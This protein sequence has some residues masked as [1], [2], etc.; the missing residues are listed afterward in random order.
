MADFIHSLA[1]Q[2]CQAPQLTCYREYVLNERRVQNQ[3]SIKEC[4]ENPDKSFIEGIL[5]PL[6]FLRKAGKLDQNQYVILIDALCEAEFHRPDYGESLISFLIKHKLIIP[7]FL[8]FIATIRTQF[9]QL[10]NPLNW[11]TISLNDTHNDDDC[12]EK[13]LQIYISYRMAQS[14]NLLTNITSANH[15]HC[16]QDS[17]SKFSKYL[18][19]NSEGSFLFAKL[20]LDLLQCGQLV[21]KSSNFR[22][23]PV[24]LSQIFLL[25]FNLRFPSLQ[26]YDKVSTILSICLAAL[27]PLTLIEIYYSL[28]SLLMNDDVVTWPEFV[29]YI[30][31][32]SGFLVKRIDNTFMFFHPSFRE[33]LI[34][35]DDNESTKFLCDLRIGHASIAFRLSRIQTPLDPLKTLELGHHVL[36]A[37]VYRN[38]SFDFISTR[39]LQAFWIATCSDNVSAAV[40]SL[41]NIYS[42]NVKVSRLLMLAGASADYV[43]DFLGNAP[44]LCMYA[45]E[46]IVTMVSLM[47]EFGANVHLANSDGCTALI[48]A[49]VKGHYEIVRLLL[50]HDAIIGQT[51]V[52]GRCALV[53]AAYNGYLNIVCLLLEYDWKLLSSDLNVSK[54]NLK[55]KVFQKDFLGDDF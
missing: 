38:L 54:F 35:R 16:Q 14:S 45:N 19:S 5:E 36:K 34:R 24:S 37:H 4:I 48:F 55:S 13:D 21:L 11:Y 41:R 50:G 22:V 8:K 17:H 53:H 7:P 49:A 1:A 25:H 43:T 15:D 51:D 29:N 31:L 30:E 9:E 27:Y 44:I 10:T 23:L 12:I 28:N 40:C 6:I 26:S 33:W 20:V 39:D 18:I 47:L 32:L 52:S 46:G 2:L 3:L 42:P